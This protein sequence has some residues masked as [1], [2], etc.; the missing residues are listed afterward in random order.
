[1]SHNNFGEASGKLLGPAIAENTSLKHLIL[2]WNN[3]RKKGA[4]AIAK[5]L[6]V[7]FINIS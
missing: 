3:L 7:L 4:I 1:L 5:G 2:S 6:Q